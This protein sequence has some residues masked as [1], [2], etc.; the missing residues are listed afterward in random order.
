MGTTTKQEISAIE[1]RIRRVFKT[2]LWA[3][4]L[5]IALYV[6]NFVFRHGLQLSPDHSQWGQFGDFVG[7]LLNPV[8]AL[9]ALYGLVEAVQLQAKQLLQAE[10]ALRI[11]S[12]AAR[13]ARQADRFAALYDE[14]NRSDFGDAMEQV[15]WWLSGAAANTK[16]KRELL[17]D[18]EI[19]SAY[20][21][22]LEK[23]PSGPMSD[24]ARDVERARRRL[25][26]WYIKC[27]LY[28]RADDL[29]ERQLFDLVTKDRAILMLQ[30]FSMTRAKAAFW[31]QL[32]DA[33]N[34]DASSD[35]DYFFALETMATK[36]YGAFSARAQDVGV[37]GLG[38]KTS[39]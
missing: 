36:E 21:Q 34:K 29:T 13:T 31:K 12:N 8:V 6:V 17:T 9:F 24:L 15:A 26:S 4:A 22:S 11:A 28:M 23:F 10:E 27:L 39:K 14:L 37:V 2:A 7:G 25:K 1:R 3:F 35:E 33:S 38:L 30:V 32:P 16:V 18:Q 19:Q 5:T 20:R